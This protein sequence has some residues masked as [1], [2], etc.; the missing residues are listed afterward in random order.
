MQ[1]QKGMDILTIF[2]HL[3]FKVNICR[4]GGVIF[5]LFILGKCILSAAIGVRKTHRPYGESA[6]LGVLKHTSSKL[7]NFAMKR[8]LEYLLSTSGRIVM[9]LYLELTLRTLHIEVLWIYSKYHLVFS[10]NHSEYTAWFYS[11]ILSQG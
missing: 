3:L 11:T 1:L 8:K 7:L 10:L 5:A 6:Y 4:I 2:V 9:C